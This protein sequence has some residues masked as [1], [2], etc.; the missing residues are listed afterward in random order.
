MSKD[1][2]GMRRGNQGPKG[3]Q[4]LPH[5]P[6]GAQQKQRHITDKAKD[7]KLQTPFPEFGVLNATTP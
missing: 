2:E 1:A 7:R 6:A 4:H 5:P 3:A